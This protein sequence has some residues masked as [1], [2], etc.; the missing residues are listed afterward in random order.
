MTFDPCQPLALTT[1]AD[2][3]APERAGVA[4]G[5]ALWTAVMPVRLTLAEGAE[6][7]DADAGATPQLPVH[8]QDAAAAFRGLYDP[9]A[10]QIFVNR[11]LAGAPLAIVVA[12]EVGHAFGLAHIS[13]DTRQSVMNPANVTVEP[14][15]ADADTLMATWGDCR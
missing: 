5:L 7:G 9:A 11:D 12:H 14:N 15:R 2:A 13:A 4:A 10:A 3:T 8:F 6:A 1:D